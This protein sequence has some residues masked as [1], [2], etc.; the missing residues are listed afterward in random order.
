MITARPTM[1]VGFDTPIDIE[2][3]RPLFSQNQRNLLTILGEFPN[4][5]VNHNHLCERMGMETGA[6]RIHIT[7]LRKCLT[8]DWTIEARPHRGYRLIDLRDK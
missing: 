1:R 5:F 6:L 2:L 4:R 8:P 7:K 3:K